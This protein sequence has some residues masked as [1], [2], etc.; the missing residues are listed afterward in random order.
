MELKNLFSPI[1]LGKLELRN[2]IVFAPIGIGAYNDDETV[3]PIYFHFIKE[4]ALETALIITQGTRP[5]VKYGGVK[6]IGTYD[7]RFIPGLAK[8]AESAHKNG[9]KIFIQTVVVGGNDPLGGYA[10]S[11]VNIPLYSN[12]W[13][14]GGQNIPKELKIEQVKELV[15]EFAQGARRAK[16]AGFDG[17]EVHAAYGY[18]ISEFI[19]PSTNVRT[20]EYGGSFEN[21]MRF[22]VEIIRRIKEVCGPDF[23][24]GFKF[25]AHMDIQPE[26]IDEKLG[27]KIAK[28]IAQEGVVYLHEVS[29]G[30]DV[31]I[32]ALGK[33]PSMPT[34]YQP[35]NT[36]VLLSEN[37]KKHI[38]DVPIICAGG[39]LDPFDS[40]KIISSGKADMVAI[41]RAFLAD[42]HWSYKA[43]MGKRF[44]PCIKCLVC[45]NEVVKRAK[46]AACSVNPYLCRE[47]EDKI[48]MVKKPR[49]VIVIGAGPAGI[50]AAV[51]GSKRGHEVTLYEKSDKVGGQLLASCVPDFKYE[52][53]TLVKYFEGEIKDSMAKLILNRVVTPDF[54]KDQSPDV[55]VIAT[56]GIPVVPE[57]AGISND[58]V[59][60]AIDCLMGNMDIRNKSIVI[61][62]G[63]EVGCEIALW[64]RRKVNDVSIVEILKELMSLEEMKY[65]TVVLERMLRQEGVKIY[66]NSVAKE[67]D[68][69]HVKISNSGSNLLKLTADYIVYATGFRSPIEKINEFK[70]LNCEFYVIG[71]ANQPNKIR[72]AVHDGDRVGRL[73]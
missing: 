55:L 9:A 61:I 40:E 39:I 24:V 2:R 70:N 59:M 56:G 63:G 37:L 6:L 71:D 1:K 10:P 27:V 12:Q 23:P 32:M 73:I 53:N 52:F 29:M 41:G 62:G 22:P 44:T 14:R 11:V 38:K 36:T 50:T 67:I 21:R 31:M 30:E 28:R 66:I 3:N 57:I 34:I 35:R 49:K 45:H 43:K 15:E 47:P 58:N 51:I 8:F 64:L 7:D 26:G 60:S 68:K 48:L 72:E 16:E 33:Y 19:C 46:L 54:I 5:S 13:G 69:S 4:R 20:D 25:N 18:L 65:H 17:V 42:P